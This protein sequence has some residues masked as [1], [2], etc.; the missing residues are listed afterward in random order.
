MRRAVGRGRGPRD[1]R[2]T[3]GEALSALSANAAKEPAMNRSFFT[4]N[5]DSV[6]AAASDNFS[7]RISA[8]AAEYGLS[9]SQAAAYAALNAA[10]QSAY[11]AAITPATRTKSSVAAKNQARIPLRRMASDL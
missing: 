11:Q 4:T 7:T 5:V 8:S 10:W 2:A 1:L 9:P 6:L 3:V